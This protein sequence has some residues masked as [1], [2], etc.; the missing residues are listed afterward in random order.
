MK[1][2]IRSR[3]KR[4]PIN[5]MAEPRFGRIIQFDERSRN[6]N[7]A[8]EVRDKPLRSYTWTLGFPV[9]DQIGGSCV[10]NGLTHELMARPARVQ[11]LDQYFALNS[12]YFEAQKNDPWPGGA[13]PGAN[14]FYEGTS[15]LAGFKQVVTL[16]YY[17]GYKWSFTLNDALLAIGYMGGGIAGINWLTDMM[18]TDSDGFIHP[19]GKIEGGHAIYIN[20]INVREKSIS[21]PNSWGEDWGISGYGKLSF[22]NFGK[23]LSD[24]G[25]FGIPVGRKLTP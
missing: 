22:D 4:N 12:I 3:Y 15:V 2:K 20:S 23:L 7:I 21:F 11:G 10:G 16:G 9:L 14:P 24:Q 13:Y 8:E 25:E 6:Y 19:T 1:P 18:N 17:T 5:N